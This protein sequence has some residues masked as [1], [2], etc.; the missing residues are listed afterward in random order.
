MGQSCSYRIQNVLTRTRL[1]FRDTK[2][3]L[4]ALGFPRAF[5]IIYCPVALCLL[6][7]ESVKGHSLCLVLNYL[8][9]NDQSF[10][11]AS[12]GYFY[13]QIWKFSWN[14]YFKGLL[15]SL[16]W[17]C[18]TFESRSLNQSVILHKV[19]SVGVFSILAG[20]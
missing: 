6:L 20:C 11:K 19:E 3:F 14:D 12:A 18:D 16:L 15:V 9:G 2:S 13:F 17:S 7:R 8:C 4:P 5:S 1:I 10:S